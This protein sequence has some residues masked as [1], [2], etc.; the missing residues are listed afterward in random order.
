MKKIVMMT[1]AVGIAAL[2]IGC[3][4]KVANTP[5]TA[6]DQAWIDIYRADYP[7]WQPKPLAPAYMRLPE[8]ELSGSFDA[9]PGI[10]APLGTTH[11]AEPATAVSYTAVE[12][13][14]AFEAPTELPVITEKPQ[15]PPPKY[16]T[17]KPAPVTTPAIK[18]TPA[19]AAPTI[20]NAVLVKD[21]KYTI[22][23]G[24]SLWKI[25]A[26]VYGKG[27]LY[28]VIQD[29]N[30]NINPTRLKLGSQIVIPGNVSEAAPAT[31]PVTTP[32]APVTV[33]VVE[34]VEVVPVVIP[35]DL[36]PTT[37]TTVTP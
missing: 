25:A 4:P 19:A 15:H 30:P 27:T 21:G 26:K 34:P 33:E 35:V 36:Q 12:P 2:A 1:A 24:D 6:K 17:T 31:A 7:S 20:T 28:K 29:A 3:Q 37:D 10:V 22:V 8:N 23:A 9:Q 14:S 11:Y 13:I 5:Y 16:N 18:L 32:P